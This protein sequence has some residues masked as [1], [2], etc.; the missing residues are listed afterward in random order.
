MT[1]AASM[2][3][4]LDRPHPV[5]TN[6]AAWALISDRVMGGLSTGRMTRET[7]AGRPALRMQGAVSVENDGGFLQIAL[8]LAPGGGTVDASG[9]SG[10]D[11]DVIGDGERYNLHLRTRDMARP[12]QSYRFAFEA[13]PTWRTVRAA[14]AAFA[15]HRI[16]VPLDPTR[17][18][19]LGV[20]AIGRAFDADVA[21]GGARFFRETASP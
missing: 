6:G 9:F 2:I 7:V 5:A 14:F 20:V 18:R 11:I 17:L 3:D 12:W 1:Q 8:D 15:P 13:G 21:I 16:D 4:A 10:I 19:R